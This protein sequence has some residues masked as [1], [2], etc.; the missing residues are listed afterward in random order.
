[1]VMPYSQL[2]TQGPDYRPNHLL[3]APVPPPL[4]SFRSLNQS[5]LGQDRH[6]MRYRWLRKLNPRF[7]ISCAKTGRSRVRSS[8]FSI[9]P[10]LFQSLQNA[11]PRR[12]GNGVQRAIK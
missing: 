2:S 1:M 8:R 6:V 7:Y 3:I 5:R 11:A 4:P 9:R 12:V 10:A